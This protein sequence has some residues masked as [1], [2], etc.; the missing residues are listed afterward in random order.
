MF[1]L[2]MRVPFCREKNIP[3]LEVRI[4]WHAAEGR[5]VVGDNVWGQDHEKVGRRL[6]RS[7]VAAFPSRVWAESWGISVESSQLFVGTAKG[8]VELL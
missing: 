7:A 8:S 6:L 2:I 5:A 3:L 1:M 4:V